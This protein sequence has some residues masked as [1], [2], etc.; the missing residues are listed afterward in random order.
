M[1]FV[2]PGDPADAPHNEVANPGLFTNC[3]VCHDPGTYIP[4][5]AIDNSQVSCMS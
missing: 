3:A 2:P 5:A 1:A 4:G